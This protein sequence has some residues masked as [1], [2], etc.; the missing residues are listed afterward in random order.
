MTIRLLTIALLAS[1]ACMAQE[2]FFR[3]NFGPAELAQWKLPSGAEI[4][5]TEQGPALK[6]TVTTRRNGDG[7]RATMAFPFDQYAGKT[8]RM[9]CRVKYEDVTKPAQSYNGTKFMMVYKTKSGQSRWLHGSGAWGSKDWHDITYSGTIDDDALPGTIELGLQDCT[10]SIWFQDLRMRLI[11]PAKVFPR[12]APEDYLPVYTDRVRKEPQRRGVM[13]PSVFRENIT[14]EKD[15]PDLA[16]WGATLIRWQL[17]RNWGARN[18][19]QDP[20]EYLEWVRKRVPEV[21]QVLDR[22]QELGMK[23]VLDLHVPPGGRREGGWMTMFENQVFADAFAEAWRILA[24]GVKGHPALF[25]YDL[26]NEPCQPNDVVL[27]DY[28]TLQYN[29]AKIVRGIDPV[30]PII[31]ESNNW[32]S[33][34]SFRYL[35]PLPLNDIIYQA[36]MYHPG[37]F[38]HQGVHGSP[39]GAIYPDPAKKWD[40]D[41]LRRHLQPVRDFQLKYNARIYIGEFSAIRWAVGAAQYLQDCIDIFEE[42]GWDWS[43]HAYRE[44]SGW[45]VEHG[46][47]PKDEKP[48]ASDTDRKKVLLEAFKRNQR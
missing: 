41:E 35:T 31:I 46:S 21:I 36:H 18:S 48:A 44:W 25:G 12:I 6:V 29:V 33:A 3:S 38:T 39:I 42:Y 30:T 43:Y 24:K 10:G 37:G 22:C 17:I 16:S 13:S 47:D 15:L 26:I 34:P 20:A 28:L 8:I 45:S 2:F 11:D 14:I 9:H 5:Q 4:V 32:S 40:K 27:I 23:V 7:D 1:A 19:D